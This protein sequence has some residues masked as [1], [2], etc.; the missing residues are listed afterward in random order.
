MHAGFV[1]RWEGLAD[2]VGNNAFLVAD[3][4]ENAFGAD[5]FLMENIEYVNS[6]GKF[7]P[8]HE[9]EVGPHGSVDSV[10]DLFELFEPGP[11]DLRVQRIIIVP[12]HGCAGVAYFRRSFNDIVV[13]LDDEVQARFNKLD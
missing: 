2:K 13:V 11:L 7:R 12:G 4:V 10:Q 1:G 8:R 3:G 9:L 5:H 6:I